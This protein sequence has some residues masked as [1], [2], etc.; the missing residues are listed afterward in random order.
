MEYEIVNNQDASNH[1]LI[2]ES[3]LR[4]C[5]EFIIISPFLSS[6]FN[7]FSFQKYSN[8]LKKI[9]LITTLKQNLGDQLN[10]ISFFDELLLFGHKNNIEIEILIDN[11]L[12]A[13]IYLFKK[14]S[15]YNCGIIT[16]ANFT[17]N[18]F[19]RNNEWGVLIDDSKTLGSVETRILSSIVFRKITRSDV[20]IFKKKIANV[21]PPK[22][23]KENPIDLLSKIDIKTN[24]LNLSSK[25]TYWLKP[26]GTREDPIPW[27][28][29]FDRLEEYLHFSDKNPSGVKIGDILIA[30]AV[31]HKNILSV[32]RVTSKVFKDNTNK[33][34][35]Y[36]VI[37]DNI[38]PLYGGNWFN[39][40]ITI[41]N[42]R[43]EVL[44]RN[45]FDITP[46]GKNSFG[47]FMYGADKLKITKEFADY[48]IGKIIKEDKILEATVDE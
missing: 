29:P 13:K 41:S 15:K 10:K 24:P 25:T 45:L 11:S 33:R 42:Q 21:K 30:Y 32:Y 22:S 43:D 19:S 1:K 27:A 3:H 46:S 26:I 7:Y 8:H 5:D 34:F 17:R 6:D 40:N 37:G 44:A 16:S 31:L 47:S 14:D 18:G 20:N 2:V 38:T 28:K 48:L 12:H 4:N 36:Y 39:Y 9:I 35:P 23:E